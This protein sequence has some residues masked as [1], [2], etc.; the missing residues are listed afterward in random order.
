PQPLQLYEELQAT[1]NLPMPAGDDDGHDTA[2]A[3]NAW[4]ALNLQ[5]GRLREQDELLARIEATRVR[6]EQLAHERQALIE[7]QQ[8]LRA[9]DASAHRQAVAELSQ[10]R[11]AVEQAQSAARA[12]NARLHAQ[13]QTVNAALDRHAA[14]GQEQAQ[15]ITA[16]QEQEQL[17]AQR[18]QQIDALKAQVAQI[19]KARAQAQE[20]AKLAAQRQQQIDAL[21]SQVAHAD[22]A[23]VQAQEQEKLAAQRQQQID[24]LKSQV[25]Q[26][27]K[28]REEAAAKARQ[29]LEQVNAKASQ[30]LEQAAA[31]ARRQ[32]EDA[33]V[34]AAAAAAAAAT[35]A[36]AASRPDP[37]LASENELLLR[38]L[39]QV[40]EELELYYLENE[41]LKA[42][43]PPAPPAL[44]GAAQRVR[45]QLPYRVGA[46][47]IEHSRRPLR[48]IGLPFVLSTLVRD[49]RRNAPTAPANEP[50]LSDYA[51]A[52]D[53][54]RART[55]L[56]WRLGEAFLAHSSS[57]LGWTRM[58]WA[59]RRAVR[60][61][62]NDKAS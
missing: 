7:Q 23:R 35:S 46:K 12:E 57:P 20:Q 49:H 43:T 4:E 5:R 55:H 11:D 32:L 51:D 19:D 56:S 59:L 9:I 29:Q 30:Q 27:E 17:A 42:A 38:Q 37:E 33:R 28:A 62:R 2:M 3:M 36:Q 14:T 52:Q 58:P 61:Y 47:L 25:A 40:Q 53:A 18:Q 24:A 54:E 13:L 8:R 44:Y 1:A 6:A 15:R 10:A 26:A 50:P 21:K 41:R 39:H 45:E 60:D 48:W 22:K 16:L 34:T 31:K